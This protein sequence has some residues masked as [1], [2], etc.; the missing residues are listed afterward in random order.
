MGVY[1]KSAQYIDHTPFKIFLDVILS[2]ISLMWVN[3]FLIWKSP[4]TIPPWLEKNWPCVASCWRVGKYIYEEI[5]LAFLIT[6]DHFDLVILSGLPAESASRCTV[7][8]FGSINWFKECGYFCLF[9]VT[10]LIMCH[11]LRP[12]IDGCFFFFFVKCISVLNNLFLV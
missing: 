4:N 5:Y 8:K 1:S 10:Y 12:C 9:L 3:L 7:Y 6:V 11:S 2:S